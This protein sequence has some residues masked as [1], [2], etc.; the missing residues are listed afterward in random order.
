MSDKLMI[1]LSD[2][3][4]LLNDGNRAK[5]SKMSMPAMRCPDK[6]ATSARILPLPPG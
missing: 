2:K 1:V 6:S 4:N 3:F 5:T